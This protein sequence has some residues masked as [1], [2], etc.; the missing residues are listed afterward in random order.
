MRIRDHQ[1]YSAQTAL[2][3]PL[4]E[5]APARFTLGGNHCLLTMTPDGRM[6]TDEASEC[7][8]ILCNFELLRMKADR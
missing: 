4:E 1:F 8:T 2:F 7:E 5:S 3:Q 6:R